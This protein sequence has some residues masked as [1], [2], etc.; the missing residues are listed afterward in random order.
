MTNLEKA[1]QPGIPDSSQI[2]TDDVMT[3]RAVPTPN[4]PSGDELGSWLVVAGDGD[5]VDV[6][7][8][9][10][11]AEYPKRVAE[12]IV[13]AVQAHALRRSND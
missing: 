7:I 3:W 6:Y 8:E 12:F 1:E 5:E 9:V 13:S 11:T 4:N 2:G 10:I